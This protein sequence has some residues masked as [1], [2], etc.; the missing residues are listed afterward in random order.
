MLRIYHTL[1]QKTAIAFADYLAQRLPFQ[2]QVIQTDNGPEFGTA[3]VGSGRI[4]PL[5][6]L[7][8][9]NVR[10]TWTLVLP[11]CPGDM[12]NSSASIGVWAEAERAWRRRVPLRCRG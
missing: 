1:N 4:R 8:R 7:P 3:F 11:N 12:S 5:E 6:P 9:R 2:I 10:A